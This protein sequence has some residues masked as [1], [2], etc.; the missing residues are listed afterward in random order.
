MSP[1]SSRPARLDLP[2]RVIVNSFVNARMNKRRQMRWSPRGAHRV[3]Q[4]R[5]AV[6]D[7]P[8]LGGQLRLTG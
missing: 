6:F 1:L 4:A 5:A 8:L 7:G 3:L 2:R